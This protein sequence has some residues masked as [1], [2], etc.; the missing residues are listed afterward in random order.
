MQI[1][2]HHAVTYVTARIAGFTHDE[3]D[4]VAY[5]AQYVDDAVDDDHKNDESKGVVHFDNGASYKRIHSAHEN[6]DSG[7]LHDDDNRLVWLPFHF[8]PGNGGINDRELNQGQN[9]IQKLICLP[10]SPPAKDMV[11]AA[12]NDKG[13]GYS[14]QRLGI[15]MHVY[16]DT[17]AHQGFAGVIHKVNKV[18]DAEEIG[19]SG[20]FDKKLGHVL[21]DLFEHFPLNLGHLH[22]GEFPDLPF[23]SWRYTNGLGELKLRNNA[24]FFLEAANAMCMEMQR[25]NGQ[26]NPTG[27]SA[28]DKELMEDIFL[29]L[30]HTDGEK[31]HKAWIDIINKGFSDPK[32]IRLFSFGSASIAYAKEG[33]DSWKEQALG[34]RY[35]FQKEFH[36]TPAFLTSNWKLFHDALQF[37]RLAVLHDILPK[38]GICSG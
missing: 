1:D 20:A 34:S 9:F 30:K 6:Y 14:L 26:T 5:S 27:I 11:Q 24:E 36:Y 13:K 31:R 22:A 18:D 2:F 28:K 16:A 21:Q 33:P 4:I 12:I 8:L 17:W 10:D 19:N 7:N 25:Y 3:A 15:A 23:L 29:G 35:F 32:G 37:H 38:Y